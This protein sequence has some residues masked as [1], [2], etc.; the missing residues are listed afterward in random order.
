MIFTWLWRTVAD[1]LFTYLLFLQHVPFVLVF[2]GTYLPMWIMYRVTGNHERLSRFYRR[3]LWLYF[4]FNSIFVR[5]DPALTRAKGAII[6]FA[7]EDP[8]E[9][10]L[11]FTALGYKKLVMVPPGFTSRVTQLR[12]ANC[13]LFFVMR[14]IMRSVAKSD[15]DF[16]THIMGYCEPQP[17][18]IHD[19]Q[20]Q[21]FF[22]E[23][24]LA[25][26]F[27]LV[28]GARARVGLGP[29]P[30]SLMMAIKHQRPVMLVKIKGK[31]GIPFASMVTPAIVNFVVEKTI[32]PSAD[33]KD[34]LDP[35][36]Q[37]IAMQESAFEMPIIDQST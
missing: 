5:R 36:N 1:T 12:Y 7:Y 34:Y 25:R 26:G 14:A 19:Y 21:S 32:S 35:Y 16:L 37:W 10:L 4:A 24:Y 29:I 33:M 18:S 8:V 20:H 28:E 11:G 23:P 13:P 31:D 9:Y 2:G 30:F 15:R 17:F 22:V 3:W 27:N 6:L